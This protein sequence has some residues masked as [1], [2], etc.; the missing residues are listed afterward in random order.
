MPSLPSWLPYHLDG[1]GLD[2]GKLR[3]FNYFHHLP[4]G[5]FDVLELLTEDLLSCDQEGGRPQADRCGGKALGA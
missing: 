5:Y 3:S 4:S 1:S 2:V